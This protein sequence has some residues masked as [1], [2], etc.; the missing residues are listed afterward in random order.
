VFVI[1]CKTCGRKRLSFQWSLLFVSKNVKKSI[2]SH[3]RISTKGI[4]LKF[5]TSSKCF[6]SIFTLESSLLCFHSHCNKFFDFYFLLSLGQSCCF[7]YKRVKFH[8]LYL[9]LYFQKNIEQLA[10]NVERQDFCHLHNVLKVDCNY[11]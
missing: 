9:F 8:N 7:F 10:L 5:K 2:Y 1:R 3:E 6:S 4:G 11:E